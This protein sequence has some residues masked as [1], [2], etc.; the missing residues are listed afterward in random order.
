M[1]AHWD[2]LVATALLGTDR[3]GGDPVALLDEAAVRTVQHRAAL[4]PGI[5]RPLPP[6]AGDDPRPGLPPAARRRLASLLAGGTRHGGAPDLTELL[7]Q[8]LAAAN[9]HGY[10]APEELLPTLLEVARARSDLRPEALVLGGPRA[11]WLARLNPQWKYALRAHGAVPEG[12]EERQRTWEEGLFAERVAVLTA[13]RRR[14]AAAGRELLAG[15]WAQERAE[16]RLLFLDALREGLGPDDEPFL[17]AALAD[18]SRNV[19]AAAAELLCTLPGSA[20]TARM[21][22]RARSCVAL[23]RTAGSGPRIV[24]E[25]PHECDR[26]MERDGVVAK[27]PSGRGERSWWLGQLVEAAPLAVWCER[28]GVGGPEEAV[29]LPV[30]DGWQPELHAAWARAAVRQQDARWARALLG[31]PAAP[32]EPPGAAWLDPAR[33]LS[34][35]PAGERAQWVARFVAANGLAD[36]FRL[37][38]A[39]AVPWAEPLGAAV[40]DA[41]DAARD[42]GGYPWSFSG[43]MGMAERCLD[44]AQADRLAALELLPRQPE[45]G[46]APGYWAEAFQRLMGTL[47]LRATMLAELAGRPG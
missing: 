17:E 24:V 18:R 38:G 41:L 20:L 46:S 22:E 47:R 11:L 21:A 29:A 26:A 45:A 35:L 31:P 28:L 39:C 1:T 13:L 7:P 42:A 33:L 12:E 37:L 5:P 15:S 23:D 9:R 30:A 2:E 8:W 32:P 6:P 10:R 3:K 44:P 14:D 25:A 36:S 34:A 19:R 40:V 16:D 27:P 4:Q 43:V